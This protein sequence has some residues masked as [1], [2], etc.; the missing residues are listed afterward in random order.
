M[1]TEFHPANIAAAARLREH[2]E[3]RGFDL[4]AFAAA[5]VLA[6]PNVTGVIAGPR[7]LEQWRSYLG[8]MTLALNLQDEEA[9]D[10]LVPPGTTAIPHYTD[11][12]YPIEGRPRS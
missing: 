10:A 9:V 3:E 12:A 2:A 1:Q 8:A 6:N 11:P 4:A 5:W 7:T